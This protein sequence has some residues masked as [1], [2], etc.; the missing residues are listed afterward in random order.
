MIKYSAR[1]LLQLLPVLLAAVTLNFV[2][3]RAA[4]GDP[5]TYIIGE[6]PLSVEAEQ[7]MRERFGLDGSVFEQ[8]QVYLSGLLRGD[9]GNSYVSRTPVTEVLASRLPPTLMLMTVQFA[10]AIIVGVVLGVAS[11]NKPNSWLDG[12][13][14]VLTV[15]GYAIPIFWLGL[16]LIYIFSVQLGWLPVAG[17]RTARFDYTGWAYVGDVGKHMI[18]PVASLAFYN[19]AVITRLTKA[20]MRETLG[21]DYIVFARS[22]GVPKRRMLY[23]HALRNALLPVVT[24]IGVNLRTLV[25]GAVLTETV[26]GWPGVGRLTFEAIG[27]RDYPVLSGVFLLTAVTVMVVTLLTDIA[28]SVIDPRIRLGKKGATVG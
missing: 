8:L 3:V 17:M 18:L 2:L 7:E 26:F 13:V 25:G 9:L 20:T 14:T 10:I 24:I 28:Y 11:A 23:R 1:R 6:V 21:Q 19:L 22:K 12:S 5:L 27:Q 4:P 16:M 15:V